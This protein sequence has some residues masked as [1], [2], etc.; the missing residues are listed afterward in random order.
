MTL[1]WVFFRA[2][3]LT[4]ALGIL[5]TIATDSFRLGAWTPTGLHKADAALAVFC[6]V[7][8]VIVE[9]TTRRRAHPFEAIRSWPRGLRWALYTGLLWGTLYLTPPKSNP[10]IYFQF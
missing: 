7:A 10:F 2:K 3:D 9:W 5:G 4:Q 8:L 1:A 6:I